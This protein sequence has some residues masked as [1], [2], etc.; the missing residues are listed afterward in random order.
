M[1]ERII[2]NHGP[3]EQSRVRALK[4]TGAG[5]MGSSARNENTRALTKPRLGVNA[6]LV[7]RAQ[8]R[9][10]GGGERPVLAHLSSAG[11]REWYY[12]L[13]PSSYLQGLS[14]LN[15]SVHSLVGLR[16]PRAW[17]DR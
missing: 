17:V 12:G 7:Q 13:S 5:V 10:E 14:A 11:C 8:V 9:R 6:R 4:A 2:H 3:V 1:A 16:S 15:C